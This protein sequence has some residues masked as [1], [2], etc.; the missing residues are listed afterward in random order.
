MIKSFNDF[1]RDSINENLNS[2]K[3][4]ATLATSLLD[5]IK[6]TASSPSSE[7]KKIKSAE[8]I[9][10]LTFDLDLIIK[11]EES[12]SFKTDSHFKNLPWEKINFDTFGFSIDANTYMDKDEDIVPEIEIVL[13]LNPN[14]ENSTYSELYFK[15]VDILAHELHHLTQAGWNR[16]PFKTY[17]S[18][19]KN[20]DAAKHDYKY[21]LLQDEVESMVSGMYARSKVEKRDL[22]LIFDQYL[23]PFI[24][25]KYITTDQYSKIVKIWIKYALENY[26]E[27]K[28]SSKVK[29]IVN[30]I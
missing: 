30:S 19:K 12:P 7:Y 5:K 2:D 24:Q 10:P 23:L 17:P 8:F 28:F 15:L 9:T 20:R 13:L 21:F 14:D 18:S 29:E 1:I 3:F 26:P 11:R 22:D 4:I 27:A 25:Y 6:K 16:Q